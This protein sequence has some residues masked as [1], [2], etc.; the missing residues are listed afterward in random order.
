MASSDPIAL[1]TMKVMGQV[2]AI[3][4]GLYNLKI[5]EKNNFNTTY[6]RGISLREII[7]MMQTKAAD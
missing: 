4:T 6:I 3:I 1:N 5:L 2:L 7:F